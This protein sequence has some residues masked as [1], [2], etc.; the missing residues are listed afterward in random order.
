MTKTALLVLDFINDIVHPRGKIARSA[1]YIQ[2]YDVIAK[3]NK[4]IAHARQKQMPIIFVKV[5]FS[6]GY[7]ELP[8]HS[9]LFS[10]MKDLAALQLGEW[11]TEFHA[12]LDYRPEDIVVVKHRV[13]TFYATDL[14]AILRAQPINHLII[15]G[16]TTNFA[17]ESATRDAHDRDYVVTIVGDACGTANRQLHEQALGVLSTIA[18]VVDADDFINEK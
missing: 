15:C 7:P 13:S 5:G 1:E 6:K 8:A 9:P 18:K 10:K 4:L 11:G 12:D 14:E 17:V 2:Q 16:V 3:A